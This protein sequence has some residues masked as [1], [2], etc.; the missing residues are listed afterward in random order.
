RAVSLG[1]SVTPAVMLTVN[2]DEDEAA[3]QANLDEYIQTFYGYPREIVGSLQ[4]MAAGRPDDVAAAITAYAD[5]GAR[6]FV[7]RLASI[8]SPEQQLER[9]A[10]ALLPALRGR[11]MPAGSSQTIRGGSS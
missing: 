10:E 7:L 8:R 6:A 11:R 9:A 4:G 5:A 3:A 1:R 2:V